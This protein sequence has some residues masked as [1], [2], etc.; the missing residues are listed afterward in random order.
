M[1]Y[2]FDISSDHPRIISIK[3][4]P[5]RSRLLSALTVKTVYLPLGWKTYALTL[6]FFTKDYYFG[7]LV[8]HPWTN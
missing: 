3:K 7:S 6:D 2:I 8:A 1:T 4:V 5:V